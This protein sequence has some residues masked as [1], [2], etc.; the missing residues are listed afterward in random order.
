M[1]ELE[2]T[3][4]EDGRTRINRLF[5]YWK[6][7]L[8]IRYYKSTDNEFIKQSES[9]LIQAILP[10]FNTELTKYKIKKPRKAF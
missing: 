2:L 9:A 5:K 8:Y 10:P 7:H 1:V 3:D 4:C 6:E